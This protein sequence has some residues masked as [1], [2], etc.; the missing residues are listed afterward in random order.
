MIIGLNQMKIVAESTNYTLSILQSDEL[1]ENIDDVAHLRIS[2]F[3][4]Y[5]YLYDGTLEYERKYLQQY[6]AAK[7]SVLI[8]VKDRERIIG[9]VTGLP[10]RESFGDCQSFFTRENISM[11]TTYYLGEIILLKE[12]RGRGIGKDLYGLFEQFVKNLE[13][14][15]QIALCEVIP[16]END[17]RQTSDY[18][19]LKDFWTKRKFIKQPQLVTYYSWKEIGNEEESR[20]PMVFW[21]KS[22]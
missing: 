9:C 10:L 19:C 16:I 17:P 18:F 3:R 1:K 20:H 11:D 6:I 4:E 21:L 13:V 22:L 14:Y 12:Y 8:V 2:V 5:P 7:N 15:R